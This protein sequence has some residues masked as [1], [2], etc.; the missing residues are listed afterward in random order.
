[1]IKNYEDICVLCECFQRMNPA[2]KDST[3]QVDR[4]MHSLDT[5]KLVLPTLSLLS[6]LMKKEARNEG[7]GYPT[8]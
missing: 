8:R 2:E 6:G 1:M 7:L 4:M 3:N 5:G